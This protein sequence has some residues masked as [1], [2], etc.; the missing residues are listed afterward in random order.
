MMLELLNCRATTVSQNLCTEAIAE[1]YTGT[2]AEY[3]QW[4]RKLDQQK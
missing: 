1:G 3:V 4:I 2:Q